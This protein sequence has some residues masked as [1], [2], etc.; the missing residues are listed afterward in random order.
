MF[1][2]YSKGTKLVSECFRNKKLINENKKLMN[3]GENIKFNLS[4]NNKTNL[5]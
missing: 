5:K 3:Y 4:R 1:Y 2:N